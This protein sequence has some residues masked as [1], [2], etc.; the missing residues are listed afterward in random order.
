M[1]MKIILSILIALHATSTYAGQQVL[2]LS[3]GDNP[4][5]NHYTQYLQTKTLYEHLITRFNPETVSIY[6]GGGNTPTT[7][8]SPFDVHKLINTKD[9]QQNKEDV[10]FTGI[11]ANNQQANKYNVDAF[12]LS[13]KIQQINPGDNLLLFVSDHGMPHGFLEDKNTNPYSNNCIDLWHYQKPF[14]NNF[15]NAKNFSK[16]CLSKNELSSLLALIPSQQVIFAMSQCYSG[17]F[18]QLSVTTQDGY[19][20][21]NTKICGFTS[22]TDDHYASGCTADANGATYQGYERSFTEWYTGHGVID[23]KKIREPAKSMLVA[24]QNAIIEDMTVDIPLSTSDYYLLQWAKLFASKQ[25]KSRTKHYDN[26]MIQS[27]YLNYK[28]RLQSSNNDALYQFMH[29][30][31]ASE[32]KIVQ[33]M[34][35]AR[36]FASLSLTKQKQ[37]ISSLEKQLEQ[38][39]KELQALWEGMMN[40]TFNVIMPSWEKAVNQSKSQPLNEKQQ[41]FEKEFYQTIVKLNLYQHPYQFEMYYLQYLSEKQND[42]DLVN[43]QKNRNAIIYQWARA[44]NNDPLANAIK[45]WEKLNKKQLSLTEHIAE[46]EKKK[47]W[48]KR[49]FTYNQIIASW[50]TL[51]TI[52][53][54]KALIDLEGLLKCQNAS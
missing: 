51:L 10:M 7:Q 13:S 36:E 19:P 29:V 42:P 32:D 48:L 17:G 8:P 4:G 50:V 18:H 11:I 31:R 41:T 53:D 27:I 9:N 25:F 1:K 45:N 43:Y 30:A 54:E 2:V 15:T 5:L 21:V 40:L 33:L 24:H 34:P 44:H 3:G 38:E 28:K 46:E 12:F 35:E 49:I 14:I 39:G 6:F 20:V 22:S 47:Q 23:G 16:A 52:H 26:N 37:K